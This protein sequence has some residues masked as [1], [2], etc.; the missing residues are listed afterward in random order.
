MRVKLGHRLAL[1]E[2]QGPFR[3]EALKTRHEELVT[4]SF[5]GIPMFALQI[6]SIAN[7]ELHDLRYGY[8]HDQLATTSTSSYGDEGLVVDGWCPSRSSQHSSNFVPG[9]L[10]PSAS[11]A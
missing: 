4:C 6:R 10:Q 5:L 2:G 1:S 9:S 11:S 3:V 8:I 7:C